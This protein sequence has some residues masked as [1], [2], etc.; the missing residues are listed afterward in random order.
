MDIIKKDLDKNKKLSIV[1]LIFMGAIFISS[2]VGFTLLI[3]KY[4]P[5]LWEFILYCSLIGSFILITNIIDIYLAIKIIKTDWQN[6]EMNLQKKKSGWRT[7][8]I[9]GPISSLIFVKN[10]LESLINI[11]THDDE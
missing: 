5:L 6:Q 7:L 10:S 1:S 3:I 4:E 9:I 11:N 2:I 8:S